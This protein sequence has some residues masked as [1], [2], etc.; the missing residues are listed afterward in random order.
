MQRSSIEGSFRQ[1]ITDPILLDIYL[2]TFIHLFFIDTILFLFLYLKN[3]EERKNLRCLFSSSDSSWLR[4]GPMKIQVH[5][6][7]PSIFSIKEL[8]STHE[9]S[10]ITTG[11]SEELNRHEQPK[12]AAFQNTTEWEDVR[13]M[14][15]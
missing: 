13:V 11:L 15:K 6:N 12:N 1:N 7:N 5:W 8:L 14:K 10:A 4:L 2:P 3:P 9:C